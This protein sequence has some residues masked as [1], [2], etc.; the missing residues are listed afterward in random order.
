MKKN[1]KIKNRLSVKF[2]SLL[3]ISVFILFTGMIMLIVNVV[4]KVVKESSFSLTKVITQERADEFNNWIDVYLKDIRVYSDSAVN[5]NGDKEEILNWYFEN[6]DKLRNKAFKN[7]YFCDTKGILYKDKNGKN[8]IS[9]TGKD[10]FQNIILNHKDE[11]VGQPYFSRLVNSWVIPISRSVKDSSGNVVGLYVGLLDYHVIYEEVTLDSVGQSGFFTL[12]DKSNTVI[13]C[14]DQNLFMKKNPFDINNKDEYDSFPIVFKNQKYYGFTSYVKNADW[15]LIFAIGEDEILYPIDYT[16]LIATIS[17]IV[18]ELV[19][20]LIV[21]LSLRQIFKKVYKLNDLI[22]DLSKGDADLTKQLPIKNNDEIDELVKSVNHFI[23]KFRQIMITVKDSENELE[24]VGTMLSSEIDNTT[25][26]VSNMTEDLAVVNTKVRNQSQQVE[27][28]VNAINNISSNIQ[29]L[30]NMIENQ[31]SSVVEA[32]SAV[33]EMIGNITSVDNSVLKMSSEFQEL[34]TETK[35]GIEKNSIISLLVKSISEQSVTLVEANNTIQ[36]ISEQTNLLAMNAAIEAAHAGE[37]GKG[38]SVVAD[39][40]R[41]LAETSEEESEKIS[42]EIL[43]IQN[44]IDQ[45]SQ[46]SVESD[47]IFQSVSNSIE[48][49]GEIVIQIKN[50]MSEQQVGSKQILTALQLMNDSTTEVR[51]TAQN[52]TS[53][54]NLIKEDINQLKILMED[55]DTTVSGVSS[56]TE[57]VTTTTA[58]LQD[59][60]NNLTNSIENISNDVNQ[61]K[62]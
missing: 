61:F 47:K 18:I 40:I 31:A 36:Q 28:S 58:K 2:G 24:N 48:S 56:Q 3:I 10:F 20:A 43:N 35:K 11:F 38:F 19:V 42:K 5:K 15:T 51:D 57:N 55:I 49:T 46:E 33:E 53:D 37:A 45:V 14:Q 22:T 32:S 9:I 44:G 41:K 39:E 29:N 1:V 62:V 60:F 34:E 4:E 17:G 27:N 23:S 7:I 54:G 12:L 6:N 21:I 26:T 13:A 30:D 16:T 52:M 59:I 50:A 25:D 8:N